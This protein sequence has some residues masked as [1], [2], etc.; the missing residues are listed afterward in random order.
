MSQGDPK[1][2]VSVPKPYSRTI[3]GA[4]APNPT[5]Y[6][7]KS[8]MP[9][10][11]R[12]T[13]APARHAVILVGTGE[14]LDVALQNALSHRGFTAERVPLK[15]FK[16][17][18]ALR[19]KFVVV[20]GDAL[21]DSEVGR[22]LRERSIPGI[23]LI[24]QGE[25]DA[26]SRRMALI[27]SGIA[28]AVVATASVEETADNLTRAS[29]EGRA[30]ELGQATLNELM[31]LI[32]REL[33]GGILEVQTPSENV[34]IVLG[35]GRPVA[36]VVQEFVQRLRPHVRDATPLAYEFQAG[37][38]SGAIA[39]H[40]RVLSGLRV[41]LVDDDVARADLLAETLRSHHARVIV[42]SVE[43][44]GLVRARGFDPEVVLLGETTT[45]RRRK[46]SDGNLRSV[47]TRD[48]F[49]DGSDNA[50]HGAAQS[51]HRILETIRDDLRLRWAKIVLV[52]WSE[53]VRVDEGAV[54]IQRLV[55]KIAPLLQSEKQV[56][57]LAAMRG[58]WDA[59]LEWTGPS[60]LLRLCLDR[61]AP[62]V[63]QIRHAKARFSLELMDNLVVS[64]HME[65]AGGNVEGIGAVAALLR[66]GQGDVH[67]EPRAMASAINLMMPLD[68]CLEQASSQ[69][70]AV[71][72]SSVP[73]PSMKG[74]PTSG[75]GLLRLEEGSG[76][77]RIPSWGNHATHVLGGAVNAN[78]PSER[79]APA[80][81]ELRWSQQPPAA[82]VSVG[83]GF[84]AVPT[85]RMEL[86]EVPTSVEEDWDVATSAR[87][88]RPAPAFALTETEPPASP[89][90]RPRKAPSV[91]ID[92]ELDSQA[93]GQRALSRTGAYSIS[94]MPVQRIELPVPGTRSQ[95]ADKPKFFDVQNELYEV[96]APTRREAPKSE[97]L[98]RAA[99]PS[100]T[101]TN[102]RRTRNV[103]DAF[104]RT[105]LAED[106]E[107]TTPKFG[108][109]EFDP[110]AFA[111][112]D[113]RIVDGARAEP[114][115]PDLDIQDSEETGDIKQERDALPKPAADA[116][117][118]RRMRVYGLFLCLVVSAFG[119]PLALL[120][121][122]PNVMTDNMRSLVA[123]AVTEAGF[124]EYFPA[125]RR[126]DIAVRGNDWVGRP[127]TQR[128]SAAR[129]STIVVASDAALV[130]SAVAD[131][132][133]ENIVAAPTVVAIS[134]AAM[135][136][137]VV[138]V[139]S[140]ARASDPASEIAPTPAIIGADRLSGERVVQYVRALSPGDR[141]ATLR[142]AL[143]RDGQDH[144]VAVAL[145][146]VLLAR[147]AVREAQP[148]AELA[149]ERRPRR[150]QYRILLGDVWTALGNAE[151][152]R[153]EYEEARSYEPDNPEVQRR[154]RAR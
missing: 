109:G 22:I 133:Q 15:D 50:V 148:L 28:H 84:D 39:E 143:A 149:V 114:S 99:R 119:A 26:L 87:A 17:S 102:V 113:T 56:A 131:T 53:I 19:P 101:E 105:A 4:G 3:I 14:K 137:S 135:A 31:Q 134:D 118:A 23:A 46:L 34:R 92:L 110:D 91:D 122:W 8:P 71:R 7:M 129:S 77:L 128:S 146:E 35:G 123:G 74:V 120:R 27:E 79:A 142:R 57:A 96:S 112:A 85:Q 107:K 40:D 81:S 32:G 144:Y 55:G 49:T 37:L 94:E 130:D 126:I 1:D 12:T 60:R 65:S 97:D 33:R 121:W 95:P 150:A 138:D 89:A 124:S 61:A 52:P 5:T 106:E 63:V 117:R 78:M 11:P 68:G 20:M 47:S 51:S 6:K 147:G 72:F 36:Q 83:D 132:M 80:A 21:L 153:H 93:P 103:P 67:V 2:K 90:A 152:A 25:P 115:M 70:V 43:G 66:V 154:L 24:E 140:P 82:L 116:G 64:A 108:G 76:P 62:C 10:P 73:P 69:T 44:S 54:D 58:V 13:L 139:E 125:A 86:N 104:L 48:S 41:L 151:A 29:T 42:S 111:S 136:D 75:S 45:G 38:D 88:S 16:S 30:G 18:L 141:E 98:E 127:V 100:S 145:A 9:T 59:K